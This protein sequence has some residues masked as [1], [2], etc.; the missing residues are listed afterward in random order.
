VQSFE[1]FGCKPDPKREAGKV[2]IA[3]VLVFEQKPG[4]GNRFDLKKAEVR[5]LAG[6][7]FCKLQVG[8]NEQRS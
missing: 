7:F 3:G 8:T 4:G 6:N 5:R 2:T 1:R